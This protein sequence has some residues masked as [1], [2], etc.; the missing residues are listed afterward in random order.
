[1]RVWEAPRPVHGDVE[2]VTL[3]LQ[4]RSGLE[5]T[6]DGA[7]RRLDAAEV[8]RRRQRLQ[9]LGGPPQLP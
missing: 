7:V 2:R 8:G 1:V 6:E 5:L 4:T 9:R 3:W